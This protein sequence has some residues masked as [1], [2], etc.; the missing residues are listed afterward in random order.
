MKEVA[1]NQPET[2]HIDASVA[3]APEIPKAVAYG[4]LG[5]KAG[6]R[7]V[8]DTVN[9]HAERSEEMVSGLTHRVELVLNGK[10]QATQKV[11]GDGQVHDL[12][13]DLAIEESSWVGLRCFPQLHTNPVVV[14]VAGK[15]IRS[16]QESA[17]WCEESVHRLWQNRSRF[18]AED[19]R[20]AA[21]A[22]YDRAIKRYQEIA[23][24]ARK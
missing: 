19:E 20:E 1:L 5:P 24:E 15:P 21:R 8:G 6:R 23:R 3:F 12:E 10:V 14:R 22:A 16:S 7:V 4:T 17:R 2:V 13:F 18:I 11:P 9:L